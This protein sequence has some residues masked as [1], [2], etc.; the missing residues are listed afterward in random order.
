MLNAYSEI[1]KAVPRHRCGSEKWKMENG[2]IEIALPAKK[3]TTRY[4]ADRVQL[5]RYLFIE[6]RLAP[7]KF[8]SCVLRCR[9]REFLA[10][11]RKLHF[12][13]NNLSCTRALARARVTRLVSSDILLYFLLRKPRGI[14]PWRRKRRD[15]EI[16]SDRL[17]NT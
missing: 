15:Q 17:A 16:T 9:Y 3:I 11:I 7:N 14:S 2:K 10:R 6:H 4:F 13:I 8:P 12:S 1:L 5:R